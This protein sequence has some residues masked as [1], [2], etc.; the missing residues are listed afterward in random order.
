VPEKEQPPRSA[1]ANAIESVGCL[2]RP[3]F[4]FIEIGFMNLGFEAGALGG[5]ARQLGRALPCIS[6]M[7]CL[8]EVSFKLL[9]SLFFKTQHLFL[10]A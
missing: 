5:S 10:H 2:V 7:L 1:L 4:P 6:F 9:N 3:S 8:S